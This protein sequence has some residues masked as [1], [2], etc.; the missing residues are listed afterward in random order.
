MAR[1][2]CA[3]AKL[4]GAMEMLLSQVLM[5]ATE[6]SSVAAAMPCTEHEQACSAACTQGEQ[7][8]NERAAA[9]R[10]GQEAVRGRATQRCILQ[11]CKLLS[12]EPL[13]CRSAASSRATSHCAASYGATSLRFA[14]GAAEPSAGE[15][16]EQTREAA[17]AHTRNCRAMCTHAQPDVMV[18]V[19]GRFGDQ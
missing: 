9:L 3:Y 13:R 8:Y 14:Q 17:V 1:L 18:Y 10:A 6:L 16:T 12:S 2:D 19:H 7:A 15:A 11:G 4:S 5:H